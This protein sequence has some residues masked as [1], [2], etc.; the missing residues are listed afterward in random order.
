MLCLRLTLT[1]LLAACAAAALIRLRRTALARSRRRLWRTLPGM[2]CDTLG[3]AGISLLVIGDNDPDRIA[4]M[5][6]VEYARFEVILLLDARRQPEA[7]RKTIDRY[8]LIAVNCHPSDE[9]PSEWIRGLYRSR[10]RCFR[11]LV[12][13]N[14][15]AP[16]PEAAFNAAAGIAAC[17][18]LLPVA[19]GRRLLPDTVERLVIALGEAP[20]GSV[21]ALRSRTGPRGLLVARERVI[22][23]GGFRPRLWHRIPRRR[24]RDIYE[25]FFCR[26]DASERRDRRLIAAALTAL[27]LF[28]A[29]GWYDRWLWASAAAT[30]AL[31]AAALRCR[32]ALADDCRHPAAPSGTAAKP[33]GQKS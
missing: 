7:F 30:A 5:L 6:A 16:S 29:A 28:A 8:R 27:A 9:L 26:T 25:P 13:V 21:E 11:R 2:T 3:G 15:G 22:A 32:H 17:D 19:A 33:S 23:E 20:A 24:R 1:L 4:A 18:Y 10:L 12:L 14:C 31:I